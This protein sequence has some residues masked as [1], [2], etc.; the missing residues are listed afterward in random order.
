MAISKAKVAMNI[1]F[2][3]LDR[4]INRIGINDKLSSVMKKI[5]CDTSNVL[6]KLLFNYKE[7]LLLNELIGLEQ[8]LLKISEILFN[9]P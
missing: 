7:H 8:R 3:R 5:Y 9:R 1:M 6:I 4:N 2:N